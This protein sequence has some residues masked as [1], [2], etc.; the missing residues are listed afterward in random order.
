MKQI[1]KL[2]HW[3][4]FVIISISYF[5]SFILQE[6]NFKIG[7]ITSLDLAAIATIITLIMFF[8]WTLTIGIYLNSIPTKPYHIKNYILFIAV[9]ICILGYSNLNLQ[10]LI[11]KNE[12][13]PF[14]ISFI[15]T[16]LTLWGIYYSFYN[17]AKLLKSIELNRE[18]KF[19]ECILDAI[20]LF[21]FPVGVWFIQPRINKILM[22]SEMKRE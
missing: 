5:I 2:K 15:T 1:V 21:A 16:P 8:S 17:V 20:T 9:C 11:F 19:S 12:I 13:F 10:R 14:W 22:A 6:D 3:Q 4:V 7:N 18:A